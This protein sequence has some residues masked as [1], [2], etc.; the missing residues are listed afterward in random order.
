[1]IMTVRRCAR[2]GLVMLLIGGGI[3]DPVLLRLLGLTLEIVWILYD[4]EFDLSLLPLAETKA[5]ELLAAF[6]EYDQ[7]V[8]RKAEE[9]NAKADEDDEEDGEVKPSGSKKRKTKVVLL[10]SLSA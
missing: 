4:P 2:M 7:S 3:I 1:M 10:S 6:D 9:K 8:E 5:R